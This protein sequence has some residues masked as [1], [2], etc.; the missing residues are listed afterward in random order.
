MNKML[1]VVMVAAG[2][3]FS[4]QGLQAHCDAIDG[5]VAKAAQKALERF[6]F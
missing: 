5:P 1:I 6:T 2:F 4:V 3:L